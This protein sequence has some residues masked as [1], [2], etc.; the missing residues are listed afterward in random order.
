MGAA[1]VGCGMG[2]KEEACR[3]RLG[4]EGMKEETGRLGKHRSKGD[5]ERQSS[6][7]RRKKIGK[8]KGMGWARLGLV[9]DLNCNILKI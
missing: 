5:E 9:S 3:V 7:R 2:E 4:R 1:S 6:P 8:R